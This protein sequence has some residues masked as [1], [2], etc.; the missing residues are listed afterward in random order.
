MSISRLSPEHRPIVA[1]HAQ[2]LRIHWIGRN[3][4][5]RCENSNFREMLQHNIQYYNVYMQKY[6]FGLLE[7]S[8]RNATMVLVSPCCIYC[9]ST[10]RMDVCKY[11]HSTVGTKKEQ[12]VG[13]SIFTLRALFLFRQVCQDVLCTCAVY[14]EAKYWQMYDRRNQCLIPSRSTVCTGH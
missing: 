6:E 8:K 9:L 14:T 1:I 11:K 5:V 4:V 10:I 12:L 3:V 13:K 2:C 7:L